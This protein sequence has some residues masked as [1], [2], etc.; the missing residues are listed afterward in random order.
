[1]PCPMPQS[2]N[3]GSLSA[4]RAQHQAAQTGLWLCRGQ[5]AAVVADLAA[6]S[7]QPMH[8]EWGRIAAAC[9]WP[10]RSHMTSALYPWSKQHPGQADPQREGPS[11]AHVAEPQ[12]SDSGSTAGTRAEK[13][14]GLVGER[15][16]QRA[17]WWS[18]RTPEHSVGLR[19]Q[20]G[21]LVG[22]QAEALAR[23]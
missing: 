3:L 6:V 14:T 17:E 7:V 10:P 20:W 13:Q 16:A 8:P 5:G 21:S 2:V 1:M 18:S 9:H 11:T 19:H 22:R 12:D 15:P 4:R 23:P